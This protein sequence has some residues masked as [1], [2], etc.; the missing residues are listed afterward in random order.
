MQRLRRQTLQPAPAARQDPRIPAGITAKRYREG[1]K[2]DRR[3]PLMVRILRE[4]FA[5]FAVKR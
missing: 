5:P 1:R 4:S 2:A 3:W